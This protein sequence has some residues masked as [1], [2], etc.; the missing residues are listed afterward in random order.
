MGIEKNK[1]DKLSENEFKRLDQA[2]DLLHERLK[3]FQ[4]SEVKDEQHLRTFIMKRVLEGAGE[5]FTVALPKSDAPEEKPIRLKD[6]PEEERMEHLDRL[7][8]KVLAEIDGPGPAL[9]NSIARLILDYRL[10]LRLKETLATLDPSSSK[11]KRAL[12]G[13]EVVESKLTSGMFFLYTWPLFSDEKRKK[14]FNR[15]HNKLL[16]NTLENPEAFM[17]K[18]E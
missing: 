8:M 6:I 12:K 16:Q 17:H 10:L 14:E 2:L 11:Y 1:N 4:V 5:F 13:I 9:R 3:E 18:E 7:M 15:I